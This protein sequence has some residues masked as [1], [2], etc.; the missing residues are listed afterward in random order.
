MKK[1]KRFVEGLK[2]LGYTVKDVENW[3]C[4]GCDGQYDNMGMLHDRIRYLMWI[5]WCNKNNRDYR[6][7]PEQTWQC[8]CNTT[9][10]YNYWATPCDEREGKDIIT[11]GS[12]C[13]NH[14]MLDGKKKHC[15]KCGKVNTR[16]LTDICFDCTDELKAKKKQLKKD[17]KKRI[18]KC[19]AYKGKEYAVCFECNKKKLEL[20]QPPPPPPPLPLFPIFNPHPL[21]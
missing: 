18:C 3:K 16:R 12:C 17:A 2:E 5:K 15:D 4:I 6:Y 8:V 19:G 11:I 7:E 20:K 21:H 9:I 13:M 1:H 14:F 10:K